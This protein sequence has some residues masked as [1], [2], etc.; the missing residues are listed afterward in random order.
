VGV[1]VHDI[2]GK[3]IYANQISR[4]L[5]GIETLPEAETEQLA[6]AYLVYQAGTEQL[7]PVENMP[8]VR[9]IRG[10]RA[11]VDDMEIRLPD[12][13]ISLEVYST[14]LLD[15]A[16]EIVAAIAAFFD[17]SER[18]Q[19]EQL[20]ANYNQTLETKVADRT[21]ELT[22]A[23]EQ[24]KREIAERKLLESK[25]YSSTQEVRAI[26]EAITD[27]VIIIDDQKN[28]QIA[29]THTILADNFSSNFINSI[30]EAFFH[31]DTAEIW[32]AKV[33]QVVETQQSLNFDYSLSINN[34]QIWFTACISPLLDNSVVWV[35]RDISDRKAAEIALRQSESRFRRL[36]DSNIIGIILTTPTGE[37]SEANDA[38]LQMVGY[39]RTDVLVSNLRWDTITPP[40]Y[41]AG[42][43][44]RRNLAAGRARTLYGCEQSLCRHYWLSTRRNDR[45][46]MAAHCTS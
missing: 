20:L 14:P 29:P 10:E 19:A 22:R 35:A 25:L 23:N 26:F 11:R 46:G 4:Q 30:V 5:L 12:R 36:A 9:S 6:Q 7:Y 41:G 42:K 43:C 32:L 40:D 2:T 3:L 15:G 44:C 39:D 21:S 27:I 33:Q 13:T 31:E 8:I 17:I 16:G 38:F 24:L 37:I 34:R 45:H 18:K 28:I 1:S